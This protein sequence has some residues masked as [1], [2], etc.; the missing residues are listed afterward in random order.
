MSRRFPIK[1]VFDPSTDAGKAA[2]SPQMA[3]AKFDREARLVA[4]AVALGVLLMLACFYVVLY[5]GYSRSFITL[6]SPLG[7]AFPCAVCMSLMSRM[8]GE[9]RWSQ[10]SAIVLGIF[11]GYVGGQILV[12]IFVMAWDL[13]G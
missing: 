8:N 10:A 3:G 4:I 7:I 1:S 12:A 11:G 6:A 5:H 9:S 13:V 2:P